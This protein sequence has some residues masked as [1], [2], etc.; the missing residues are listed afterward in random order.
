LAKLS[1]GTAI[2]YRSYR[3]MSERKLLNEFFIYTN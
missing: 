2:Q 3:T 1:F